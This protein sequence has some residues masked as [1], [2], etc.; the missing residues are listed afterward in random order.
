MRDI[1]GGRERG[2]EVRVGEGD[3]YC[4]RPTNLNISKKKKKG[5]DEEGEKMGGRG[6]RGGG[7][8]IYLP[9]SAPLTKSKSNAKVL[10]MSQPSTWNRYGKSQ[11]KRKREKREEMREEE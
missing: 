6:G 10:F 9:R 11:K 8:M 4:G 5:E 1:G 3:L 2:W 7:R